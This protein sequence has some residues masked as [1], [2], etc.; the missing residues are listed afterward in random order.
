M[1]TITSRDL[2]SARTKENGTI[3]PRLLPSVHVFGSESDRSHYR[4]LKQLIAAPRDKQ[5]S[6]ILLHDLKCVLKENGA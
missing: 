2:M 5:A 3:K 6:K 1:T 4:T